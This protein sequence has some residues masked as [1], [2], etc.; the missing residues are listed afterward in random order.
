MRHVALLQQAARQTP[1]TT[2]ETGRETP[3]DEKIVH[4]GRRHRQGT[5]A[6]AEGQSG[7]YARAQ[8]AKQAIAAMAAMGMTMPVR[9]RHEARLR[10][11]RARLAAL[12]LMLSAMAGL[13]WG[14]ATLPASAQP[15][16]AGG[17]GAPSTSVDLVGRKGLLIVGSV[18]LKEIT[19]AV[20]NRL[21]EAYVLP[22]PIERFD[23]TSAG[24]AAFCAGIGP[25]YPDIVAATDRMGRG[26]FATCGENGVRDV[27]EVE[28]GD[29]AVVVVAKKG[30][31][32]F[33]L[34]PR[35]AYAGLAEE[36]PVDGEFEVNLKK[37]WHEVDKDAPDLPIHVIIPAK[38]SA[39][40]G[41]FNDDFMEGG[42]RH[43]KEIDAIF[44][45]AERV[46]RCITLRHDGAVSEVD[47]RQVI[48]ALM[49]A[50]RGT[51]AIVGWMVYLDN[52]DKLDTLPISGVQPSHESISNDSYA[53]TA[54]LRYYF[55][56]A[57]MLEKLGGNGVVRG[58]SEFM[59]EIASDKASGEDG[60]LEKLGLVA[61]EPDERRKQ[62]NIVRR[63]RRFEP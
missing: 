28:I 41:F 50:P 4:D 37:S 33:N 16:Q 31:P 19:D 63:L 2:S 17:A 6:L 60:Y 32:V 53:M 1:A 57:H 9:N 15:P 11:R 62:L 59:A 5:I 21:S 45:A 48:D 58:I 8:M 47:E 35:M 18:T 49:K 12:G 56:R 42:C 61:L 36:V 29:T 22:Q 44:A 39:A 34:T 13:C 30:D 52:R 38:G 10:V 3:D 46:P 26:E 54:R 20:I 24:I 7:R 55:K 14:M 23:G 43:V 25:Q 40:R 51:L 27:I